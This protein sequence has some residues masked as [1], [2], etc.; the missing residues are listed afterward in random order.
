PKTTVITQP[1]E[2]TAIARARRARGTLAARGM[3][4]CVTW[5]FMREEWADLF[6]A[7]DYQAAPALKIRNPISAELSQM[8]PT[9]LPN[10]IEAAGNNAAKGYPDAALFEIGPAFHTARLDGQVLLA[11]GIRKG[12]KGPRHWSGEEAGRPVD[13]FDAKADALAT[14]AAAGAPTGNLSATR[15]A[16]D[17]YHPGRSG[18]LRLGKNV[19]AQFGE[20]HPAVLEEMDVKGPVVG[21]EIFLDNIPEARNVGKARKLLTLSPFQPVNRDFAFIVDETVEAG[22]I[23][24][25]AGAAD[26]T[27]V[28]HV[29]VFDVYQGKGV[30]AGKKSVALTVTLQPT[31]TTLTDAEIDS[32]SRKIV[33]TVAAK[34]G[35]VLRG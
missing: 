35:G 27:L 14:L 33:D 4:E 8:R 28:A 34:T 30:E 22:D 23:L 32:V 26:K 17:W 21:F 3:N 16:P 12:T 6:G 31:D 13:L 10:L 15:D 29:D 25:A 7:N 24:R 2:T 20:I 9:A 5:S 18:V 19:L 1:A 11:A